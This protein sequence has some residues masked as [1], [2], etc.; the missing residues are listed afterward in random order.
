M[1]Y[2]INGE[3]HMHGNADPKIMADLLDSMQNGTSPKSSGNE[4]LLSTV[5]ALAM[6][7]SRKTGKIVN[8]SKIWRKLQL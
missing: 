3:S 8:L 6:E 2:S 5:T 7:K 1:D 4:G